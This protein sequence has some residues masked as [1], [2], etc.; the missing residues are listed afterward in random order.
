MLIL[1]AHSQPARQAAAQA[2]TAKD[3]ADRVPGGPH[4][5]PMELAHASL[6]CMRS[7]ASFCA[8]GKPPTLRAHKQM[9]LRLH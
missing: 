6:Q 9:E 4:F 2:S 1:Q 3:G 7:L 5:H 8:T